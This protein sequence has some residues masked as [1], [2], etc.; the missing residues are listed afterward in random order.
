MCWGHVLQ[1]FYQNCLTLLREVQCCALLGM[2]SKQIDNFIIIIKLDDITKTTAFD[3][4][5]KSN[6]KF[7]LL[8]FPNVFHENKIFVSCRGEPKCNLD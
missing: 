8:H 6:Y 1:V 4:A 7:A 3:N 2:N 5:Y